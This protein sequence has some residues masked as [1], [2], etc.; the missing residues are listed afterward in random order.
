MTKL[1]K[2]VIITTHY[3][4]DAHHAHLV[5]IYTYTQIIA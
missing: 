3:I 4:Q 5:R 2:T 1:G